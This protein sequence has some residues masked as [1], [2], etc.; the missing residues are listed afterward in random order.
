[1][2]RNDR[3]E[4]ACCLKI[5]GGDDIESGPGNISEEEEG[6]PG[7]WVTSTGWGGVPVGLAHV[8]FGKHGPDW[9]AKGGLTLPSGSGAESKLPSLGWKESSLRRW[10]TRKD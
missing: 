2:F 4:H 10:L 8:C 5:Y 6:R 9:K 1:M 7:R 3:R